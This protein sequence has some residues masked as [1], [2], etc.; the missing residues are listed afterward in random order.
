MGPQGVRGMS[1]GRGG[2]CGEG[3][4]YS[5]AEP[6]VPPRLSLDKSFAVLFLR[7]FP[8]GQHRA[9]ENTI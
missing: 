2:G 1:V 6:E 5:C 4:K 3:A 8:S 7:Q 9:L